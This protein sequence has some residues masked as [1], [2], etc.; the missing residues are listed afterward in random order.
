MIYNAYG[1]SLLNLSSFLVSRINTLY[2]VV[3]VVVVVQTPLN[4]QYGYRS[5]P[6]TEMRVS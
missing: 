6:D 4:E 1:C 3:V 2:V 5:S